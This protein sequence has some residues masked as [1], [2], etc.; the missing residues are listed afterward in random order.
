MTEKKLG[1]VI[2]TDEYYDSKIPNLRFAEKDAKEIR[3]ILLDSDIC[4]FNEVIE[5]IN[6]TRTQTFCELDQLLKKAESE[7]SFLI[8]FSGHGE[9]DSQ[10]DLCLLFNNTR[11][12]CLLPTSLNYSMIRKSIDASNCKKVVVI[13]D[14]CYSGAASIKGNNLKETFAK[15]SGSGTVLLSASSEFDVAKEDEKLE[16]GVFTHYLIEG[17]RSGS[18]GGDR[19]GDISLV[20]LYNYAHEKTTARYSQTPYIKVDG[21]GKFIIGKNPLKVKEKEFI[22][23][24][25]K[26]VKIRKELR[27][28]V[29][30]ISMIVLVNAY[31]KPEELTENDEEIRSSLEDLLAGRMSVKTYIHTVQCYIENEDT[32]KSYFLEKYREQEIPKTFISPSTE[33]EFLLILAGRFSMG[34]PS[35]EEGR[36][37]NEGPVHKVTI[38][39]PFYLGK[40]PVTQKQWKKIMDN[41]P[42]NFKG[43]DLPV[44][45]VS[46][47]KVQEFIKRLNQTEETDMYRLPSEAEWEYTCRAGTTTRYSF[48][49][50]ESELDDY[51]W[52]SSYSTYEELDKNRDKVLKEG[53]THPVGQKKSN[54]WSLYDMHGNVWEWIQDRWHDNY[55]G[56]PSDGSAWED[57]DKTPACYGAAAGT[58][59][60]RSAGRLS[61]LGTKPTSATTILAS[62]F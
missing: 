32:E 5:C 30:D 3:D 2:G 31:E 17:L 21:E 14:C 61:A 45:S 57:G 10:H 9:P 47:N 1:I 49:D 29:Y 24:K 50:D 33:M 37:D 23:K 52:Y 20:D 54:A 46:W 48:G 35:N 43:D 62:V 42:S 12:D 11:M 8:Y 28:I 41:N 44:E 34:S 60:P 7:D 25:N 53:K 6:K 55:E 18:V 15:A 13:L 36:Y 58:S 26:L 39:N 59:L 56:A 40:Y 22:R 38:K 51:C 16:H 4:G 19:N 27:P